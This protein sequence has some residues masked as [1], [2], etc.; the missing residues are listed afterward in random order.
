MEH[1]TEF[2]EPDLGSEVRTFR[3]ATREIIEQL[4]P[5]RKEISPVP[6]EKVMAALMKITSKY[7]GTQMVPD[8]FVKEN[9][10]VLIFLPA[11]ADGS[12]GLYPIQFVGGKEIDTESK[13]IIR[14]NFFKSKLSERKLTSIVDVEYLLKWC[15]AQPQ[16]ND[17]LKILVRSM[18]IGGIYNYIRNLELY[19]LTK[20]KA[21][22]IYRYSDGVHET[23]IPFES[24]DRFGG[25]IGNSHPVVMGIAQHRVSTHWF[26]RDPSYDKWK[27]YLGKNKFITST[28][29]E[30]MKDKFI[31]VDTAEESALILIEKS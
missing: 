28:I 26:R 22:L 17:E 10:G 11:S 7:Y 29:G 2:S 16:D 18:Q 8:S 25:W 4:Y 15:S 27:G 24:R 20:D 13:Q 19:R 1:P 21:A 31:A 5:D 6:M 23:Q 30:A 9:S 14:E 12:P 3:L